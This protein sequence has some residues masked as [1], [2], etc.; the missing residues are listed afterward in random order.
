MASRA[1][2][3]SRDAQRA[4]RRWRAAGSPAPAARRLARRAG[5]RRAPD[6]ARASP[7]RGA[8]Q[9][10]TRLPRSASRSSS[11]LAMAA[12]L[13]VLSKRHQGSAAGRPAPQIAGARR[14]PVRHVARPVHARR[15]VPAVVEHG[16]AAVAV[17][18]EPAARSHRLRHARR[19]GGGA[20]TRARRRAARSAAG[21]NQLGWRGSQT[22]APANIS[23]E[24][25]EEGAH[26]P[27]LEGERRRQ[28]HQ[29]HG[30]TLA[31]ARG[32]V[33]EAHAGARA[34]GAAAASWSD[35]ARQLG[36]EAEVGRRRGGPALDRPRRRWLRWNDELISAQPSTR[37]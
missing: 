9:A 11:A 1:S 2:A 20:P 33:E 16:A 27:A 15:A 4:G 6:G 7:W 14:D 23:A 8:V 37:A 5:A 19:V 24:Q 21:V 31:Q 18:A 22:T 36:S 32:L 29:Q 34:H 3:V 17:G 12:P 35:G 13:A 30:E 26:R 10:S 25:G 28:L